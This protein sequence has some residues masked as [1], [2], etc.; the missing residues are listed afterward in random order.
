MV[1]A[2]GRPAGA[3]EPAA[4]PLARGA[5]RRPSTRTTSPAASRTGRWSGCSR[6]A[7]RSTCSRA[8]DALSLRPWTQ[9]RPRAGAPGQPEHRPAAHLRPRRGPRRRRGG[10]RRRAAALQGSSGE[11]LAERFPDVPPTRSASWPASHAPLAQLPPRGAGSSRA[12]SSTSY[13]DRWLGGRCSEPDPAEIVR[14]YLRA[15]G[16][17]PAADVTAWSGVTRLARCSQAM[18]DLVQHEDEDGR[19]L[20]D[21]PGGRARRRGRAR[22]GPAARRLRQRLALPRRPRPGHRP[23]QAQAAG[24]ASTAA[25][26]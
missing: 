26:A 18:D 8:E 22:A 24:W 4:V 2:P 25:S 3:G 20:Y 9:P 6:C 15:F 19:R 11:A 14:R 13:V 7:A 5:A 16:P 1:A 17:A 12:A 10:A 21:V 23:R